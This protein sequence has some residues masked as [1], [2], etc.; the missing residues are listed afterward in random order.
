M[1]SRIH[2][3]VFETATL[4][5]HTNL[6][7][8]INALSRLLTLQHRDHSFRM[9]DLRSTAFA[10]YLSHALVS[11]LAVESVVNQRKHHHQEV[12]VNAVALWV[13]YCRNAQGVCGPFGIAAIDRAESMVLYRFRHDCSF[14][15]KHRDNNRNLARKFE[16]SANCFA[17]ALIRQLGDDS[18]T[19]ALWSY[20]GQVYD[21]AEAAK[22]SNVHKNPCLHK[23]DD[24]REWKAR[25]AQYQLPASN[26]KAS[27]HHAEISA[28]KSDIVLKYHTKI[29]HSEVVEALHAHHIRLAYNYIDATR[30]DH[31][32]AVSAEYLIRALKYTEKALECDTP[33]EEQLQALWWLCVICMREAGAS[34]GEASDWQ[35]ACNSVARLAQKL[36]PAVRMLNDMSTTNTSPHLTKVKRQLTY[37]FQLINETPLARGI[38]AQ[39]LDSEPFNA[40]INDIEW[41]LQRLATASAQENSYMQR[42]LAAADKVNVG[43]SP[44][45]PHIKQCWLNA[46]EQMR[47]AVAATNNTSCKQYEKRSA[48]QERLA[49]GP[50]ST[51]ADYFGK[52]ELSLSPQAKDLWRQAA[53]LSLVPVVPF[54]QHCL[55]QCPSSAYQDFTPEDAERLQRAHQ[56][57]QAAACCEQADADPTDSTA[58]SFHK[59]RDAELELRLAVLE[60]DAL[61]PQGLRGC[62]TQWTSLLDWCVQHPRTSMC[63]QQAPGVPVTNAEEQQE[64]QHV[65]DTRI[66]RA[67]WLCKTVA[68]VV[69]LYAAAGDFSPQIAT[70]DRIVRSLTGFLWH[71]T[72]KTVTLADPLYFS[73]LDAAVDTLEESQRQVVRSGREPSTKWVHEAVRKAA[74][75][76]KR[77]AEYVAVGAAR[78]YIEPCSSD[79]DTY[80]EKGERA[81]QAGRWYAAAAHAA[82]QAPQ[83]ELWEVWR[84]Y[85][86][87]ATFTAERG[88]DTRGTDV[89]GGTNERANMPELRSDAVKAGERFARAAEVYLAG[90]RKLYE[91]WLRAAEAT[92]YHIDKNPAGSWGQLDWEGH[93]ELLARVAQ[94]HQDGVSVEKLHGDGSVR[95]AD[96]R[97]VIQEGNRVN[98]VCS[99]CV[100]M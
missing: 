17:N 8:S 7:H 28:L 60:W 69:R 100:V 35:S 47:L 93:P 94:E 5:V 99:T 27:H 70:H 38:H 36:A 58:C 66:A 79:A 54:I 1:S 88:I 82:A 64:A 39:P 50:L 57:A 56:L 18:S 85:T 34:D 72:F 65:A 74:E 55:L 97:R 10:V 95:G 73:Y 61:A 16:L 81:R 13:R 49:L 29:A 24:L 68:R 45:H 14:E 11:A 20:A 71:I 2:A 46:A 51:T 42:F 76:F 32:S 19:S 52:A 26:I 89:T 87:A 25:A 12:T 44:A 22:L 33:G 23:P 77:S 86:M 83:L 75:Q 80:L 84:A 59:L 98:V 41:T 40:I 90:D 92:A 53:Q 21:Q 78:K 15:Q 31:A 30:P 48:V 63:T 43:Q 62:W 9:E 3:H 67:G 37:V 4:G 96:G 6:V 91:L